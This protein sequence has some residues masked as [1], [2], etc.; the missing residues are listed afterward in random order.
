MALL[1]A[2]HWQVSIRL[3]DGKI[4]DAPHVGIVEVG[5]Q[6]VL[7]GCVILAAMRGK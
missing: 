5:I 3:L 2:F 1:S 4:L 7:A 6:G